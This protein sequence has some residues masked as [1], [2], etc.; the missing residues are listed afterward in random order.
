MPVTEAF[1]AKLGELST[2]GK[3]Q[4]EVVSTFDADILPE[5]GQ[6]LSES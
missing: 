1:L 4:D 2:K 6:E 3:V 5:T